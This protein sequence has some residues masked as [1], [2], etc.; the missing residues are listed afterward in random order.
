MNLAMFELLYWLKKHRNFQGK[1]VPIWFE[2]WTFL[3]DNIMNISSLFVCRILVSNYQG[4]NRL[5]TIAG[6]QN[7]PNFW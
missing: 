1:L 2:S 3:V 6:A 5:R 7:V 4:N